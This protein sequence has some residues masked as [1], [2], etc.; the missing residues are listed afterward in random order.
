MMIT[1]RKSLLANL[2]LMSSWLTSQA[3]ARPADAEAPAPTSA[4][5]RARARVEGESKR[6]VRLHPLSIKAG[7]AVAATRGP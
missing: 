1:A 4:G 3:V 5:Q 2:G 6:D 7:P